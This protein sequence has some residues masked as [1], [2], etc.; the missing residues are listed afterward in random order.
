MDY[1][2]KVIVSNRTVY[3]EFEITPE[4]EIVRLG[5][6]SSCEFRL[7]PESFF[8]DIEIEYTK[9][10]NCWNID[11]PDNIYIS[12]GDMR[13][14]YSSEIKHGDIIS[15]CYASTGNEAFEL[16]FMIDFEA[17]VPNYNWYIDLNDKKS[18]LISDDRD[19][20]I[21]L[22][23]E[24]NKASRIELVRCG[25]DWELRSFTAKYGVYLNGSYVNETKE[26]HD[27]DF[28]FVGDASFFIRK[29][30]IYFDINNIKAGNANVKEVIHKNNALKYPLFNR[31]TRIK[32]KLNTE[33]ISILNP[34]S[35]PNKPEDNL[36]MTLMPALG[37][38]ALTVVV[39][40]FM[41]NSS[42]S[43]FIIFSVCSMGMGIAT[44][45][46]SFI[47][48]KKK[49]NVECEK[50]VQEY[51]KYIE[52]KKSQI[53]EKREKEKNI[54]EDIHLDHTKQINL[55][56]KFS[57]RLFERRTVDEDFLD[58]YIGKGKVLAGQ[59]IKVKE[60]EHFE[61]DDKLVDV[62]MEL[63]KQY[64]YISNAPVHL[65][66]KDTC[67]IGIVGNKSQQEG[68]F[69]NFVLDLCVRQ[70]YG[71]VQLYALIDDDYK[72]YEWLKKLPHFQNASGIRNIVYDNDSRGN[73]FESLYRELTARSEKNS[74]DNIC[75]N[76]VVLVL[77]ERGLKNH[78]LS[79]FIEMA[80][81][82]GCTFIFFEEN[83][84]EL[85]LCCNSIIDVQDDQHVNL[86]NSEDSTQ[87]MEVEI[88]FVD[89]KTM[90]M[91]AEKM[92]PIHCEEISL[93]SSLRKNITLYELMGIYAVEDWN[94][95]EHWKQA[96]IYETMDTPL[97]IN[98]K[99]EIVSLNLHEKYHG[100]HG[101]V[102]GT[103][104]SGKSEI[105]Q[106][107]ILSAAMRFHPFE[108]AFVIIDFKGGG[109]VNQFR[110]LPHLV[111][112][113]TNI[114]GREMARS[115]KSIKAE[116]VKRQ[117]L[118]A[119]ANVNHIDKYIKLYKE[120][121]V[122]KPLPHLVIIVDEFAE[123]KAEQ[124][125]FMKELISAARIGRSLGVHLILATQK[126]S[127]QVNEQ[128]WSNSKFRLCLKVQNQEDSKEVL[129]SP[130][131][132][133][134][135][136]PGRAYLQVGNNEIFELFQSAYSGAPS[137][138]DDSNNQKAFN[139]CC[140]DFSG[141]KHIV[142]VKK[143]AK[144]AKE[145]ATQ[146]DTIVEYINKYCKENAIEKLPG[147][148]LPSLED[149]I[150]Y[151]NKRYMEKAEVTTVNI[152]VY[153]DPDNQLQENYDLDVQSTNSLVIGTSMVGKT[154]L[155]QLLIRD[156]SE[157]Y[158]PQE[159]SIYTID[160]AS[161]ALKIFEELH[162]VGGV[163]VDTD[164]E[165]MKHFIR[166]ILEEIAKRKDSFAR[167]GIT[168]FNSYREAGFK[169]LSHILILVDNFGGLKEI[170]ADYEDDILY[171]LREGN[172]VGVSFFVTAKQTAGI[173]YRYMGNFGN[174][175]CYT[176]NDSSEYANVLDRCRMEM[177]NT[178]GR[179]LMMKDKVIYEF[180]T[181]LAF[182]GEKEI[183]RVETIRKYISEANSRY[184]ETSAVKIPEIPKLL[185][186]K[187]LHTMF[188]SS[189]KKY[190][191]SVAVDY[192]KVCLWNLD[193]AKMG[194][195][196]ISGAEKRGKKNFVRT[197]L[198]ALQN[199]VFSDLCEVAI[200]DGFDRK[201]RE[202][203]DY[204]VV[205]KYTVDSSEIE[206]YIG[207]VESELEN[208]QMRLRNGEIDNQEQL[209][210][211]LTIINV[212][213]FW[214]G[215]YSKNATEQFKRVVKLGKT[216]KAAF[217]I[218]NIENAAIG[219]SSGEMMKY[220]KENRNLLFFDNLSNLKLFDVSAAQLRKYKKTIDVG[221]AYFFKEQ[222]VEKIK[223]VLTGRGV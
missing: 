184:A 77:K 21:V 164:D 53:E 210:L 104:G 36:V 44:S 160:L 196:F 197:V 59:K 66:L 127:G 105:L 198:Y 81:E 35:A 64:K 183:D 113:I 180:Q 93:E 159:V 120:G 106:S 167:M 142:Y 201:Y 69:R 27:G 162:H 34:P 31:N 223:T 40:G 9:Q 76:I 131:A 207:Q 185:D 48:S 80:G 132:A 209:P 68:L 161:K 146:L 29:D 88:E 153:D 43:S 119:E 62:P 39:R 16:R 55:V 125:E 157:K 73:I 63:K 72:K 41:S 181:Y 208:R 190:V 133:E 26:I 103:T 74:K 46:A 129:K 152:G 155:L 118:F 117:A 175:F 178:P 136:E 151:D 79:K 135:R 122:N 2:Y 115:L 141:K 177:K 176:C 147:I 143:K 92:T 179:G 139:I 57:E 8:E 71:D 32:Y 126:P 83:K 15:V 84:E 170:F 188:T 200:F 213:D 123:L 5:T 47:Q 128:I 4:M 78:P 24:F 144:A 1:Q 124:P 20:D 219:F 218:C 173:G 89:N 7:N 11:C 187:T 87:N 194:V 52:T 51:E 13:K 25:R 6:T 138:F 169:D 191:V 94:L 86:I 193:L 19:S 75:Q 220:L 109:M 166:M 99:N 140:V 56:K 189:E 145:S 171:I 70:F 212:E 111:G 10:D 101:L 45:I 49:Y 217:I 148:C 112:A 165:K 82:I 205:T 216:M 17:K 28:I 18:I 156:I 204:G 97:G 134:I 199:R 108:I 96:K 114:D 98:A 67:A 30:K 61:T 90:K 211:L 154:S 130:L 206:N 163:I 38:L 37:M 107:Y 14:L 65:E 110:N 50:R 60:Q 186:Q 54:L 33:D 222:D 149:V 137:A 95:G 192:E 172:A 58:I 214:N 221:D 116:L 195:I 174:R 150:P 12:R 91:V 202:F 121:K 182:A 168:S 203:E 42:N 102:A 85:P 3:K 100:P 22:I 158:S 23:S 215:N